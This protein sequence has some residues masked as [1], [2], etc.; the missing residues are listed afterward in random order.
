MTPRSAQQKI[1]EEI[2]ANADRPEYRDRPGVAEL[3][4]KFSNLPDERD[5]KRQQGQV[6]RA[7]KGA[8]KQL[9]AAGWFLKGGRLFLHGRDGNWGFITLGAGAGRS[10]CAA[11]VRGDLFSYLMRVLELGDPE[12]PPRSDFAVPR[13]VA[14]DQQFVLRTLAGTCGPQQTVPWEPPAPQRNN[15]EH[16]VRIGR[17][18]PAFHRLA[19]GR[20]CVRSD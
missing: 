3:R 11:A 18:Q 8:A 7:F 14:A 9:L 2:L 6:R 10:P 1:A 20:Q 13:Y 15:A 12:Q 19:V 4:A 16:G 17:P 5:I